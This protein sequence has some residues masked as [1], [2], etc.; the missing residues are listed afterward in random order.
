MLK[1]KSARR[2]LAKYNHVISNSTTINPWTLWQQAIE[3]EIYQ[4]RKEQYIEAERKS[5]RGAR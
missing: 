3:R 4:L 5:R 1:T 2:R